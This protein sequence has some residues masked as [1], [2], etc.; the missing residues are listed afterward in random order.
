MAYELLM[1][2]AQG[3]SESA[4]MEVVRFMRFLKN[5]AA[6]RSEGGED[7]R[8]VVRKAGLYRGKVAMSEDFDAPLEEF[9]EYM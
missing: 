9:K 3:M 4:L 8:P 1:R 6:A 5:E 2:E 7:S